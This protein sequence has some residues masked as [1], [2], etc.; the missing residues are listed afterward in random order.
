MET[1]Y[2]SSAPFIDDYIIDPDYAAEA[3]LQEIAAALGVVS[4]AQIGQ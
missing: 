1:K 2:D 4:Y 3:Y